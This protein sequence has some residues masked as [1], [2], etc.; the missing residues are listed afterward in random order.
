M[1]TGMETSVG[2]ELMTTRG[3]VEDYGRY[4]PVLFAFLEC[5]D[6]LEVIVVELRNIKD[7]Q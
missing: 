2:T 6:H 7:L 4:D 1:T 5:R 3:Q